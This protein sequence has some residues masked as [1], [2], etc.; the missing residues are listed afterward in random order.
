MTEDTD[1]ITEDDLKEQIIEALDTDEDIHAY[2]DVDLIDESLSTVAA[3]VA[4]LVYPELDR[5]R[6]ELEEAKLAYLLN[7]EW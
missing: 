1:A 3:K 5:L 7:V 6:R 4:H 2:R